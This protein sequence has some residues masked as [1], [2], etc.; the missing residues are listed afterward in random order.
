MKSTPY[1]SIA[2]PTFNRAEL[3]RLAIQ[4]V[5]GQTFGDFEVVISNGGSTDGTRSVVEGFDDARIRYF[6]SDARRSIGDN[7]QTALDQTRGEYDG[8]SLHC[9][10][11]HSFRRCSNV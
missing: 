11:T 8:E 10:S 3:L 9:R 7:Y 6:E 4:S 1:F 2:M 5:L